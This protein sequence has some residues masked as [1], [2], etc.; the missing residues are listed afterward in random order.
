MMVTL[1]KGNGQREIGMHL[2]SAF[3]HSIVIWQSLNRNM[4]ELKN[5]PR[6]MICLC[7]HTVVL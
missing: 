5:L 7:G 6:S 4:K 3:E 1:R 2:F